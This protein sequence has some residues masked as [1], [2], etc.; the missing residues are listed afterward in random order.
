MLVDRNYI[1]T[2]YQMGAEAIYS[3]LQQIEQRV[4]DAEARAARS[5][6][7]MAVAARIQ[8]GLATSQSRL[9]A[10]RFSHYACS[11]FGGGLKSGRTHVMTAPQL[12]RR[13]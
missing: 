10:G 8:H 1:I 12:G 2:L 3:Y 6:T 7:R 5:H 13:S 4:Q 9:R 11:S